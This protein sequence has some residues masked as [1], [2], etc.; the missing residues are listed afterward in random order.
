MLTSILKEQASWLC[1]FTPHIDSYCPPYISNTLL[2]PP[3]CLNVWMKH[4]TPLINF[5]YMQHFLLRNFSFQLFT[6]Y[7]SY[8]KALI[9]FHL[10]FSLFLNI[11]GRWVWRDRHDCSQVT[12]PCKCNCE[13]VFFHVVVQWTCMCSNNMHVVSGSMQVQVCGSCLVVRN[14]VRH[15]MGMGSRS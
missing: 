2:L 10:L 12:F 11:A 9:V 4:C 6:C 3:P 14:V 7:T 1:Y 15:D 13:H 5:T 8:K